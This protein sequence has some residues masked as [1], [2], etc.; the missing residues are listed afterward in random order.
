MPFSDWVDFAFLNFF[1]ATAISL[2]ACILI[3]IRFRDLRDNLQALKWA[4]A[5]GLTH[6][7]FPMI[8]FMG[9]WYLITEHGLAAPIYFI[10]AVALGWLIMSVT[11]EA[12]QQLPD[13]DSETQAA[14]MRYG[15]IM[16]FWIPVLYV[17]IDAFLSGPGKTVLLDRYPS[18]FA[19]LSFLVVGLVVTLFTV[20]AGAVSRS[21]HEKWVSNT[22]RSPKGIALG[23]TFGT[24]CEITLFSFFLIWCLAKFT[25]ELPGAE[26]SEISFLYVIG[27]AALIGLAITLGLSQ[28][29]MSINML[30]AEAAASQRPRQS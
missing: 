28:K 27:V 1:A 16:A 6:A 22:L 20:L 29:M 30:K 18:A 21:I 5:V 26:L 7:L 14:P 19:W 11:K 17:S 24:V 23:M 15:P 8:G 3:I 25:E 9:G 2:D 10:G 12:L 13:V 4:A